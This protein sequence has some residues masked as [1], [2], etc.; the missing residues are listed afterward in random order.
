MVEV[1]RFHWADYL[2]FG[3]FLT[4]SAGIGFFFGWRDRKKTSVKEFLTGGK[5]MHW[6]PVAL[7]MQVDLSSRIT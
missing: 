2:V 5:K 6:I 7:S 3:I 4:V 1:K